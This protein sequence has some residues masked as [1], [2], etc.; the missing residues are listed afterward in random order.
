MT[1]HQ[2][3]QEMNILDEGAIVYKLIGPALIKQD[4]IEAKS[5]VETRLELIK[6]EQARLESQAKNVEEKRLQKEKQVT[7]ENKRLRHTIVSRVGTNCAYTEE[8]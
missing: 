7:A 5:N 6:S 4:P 3:L 8:E 1:L 2:H